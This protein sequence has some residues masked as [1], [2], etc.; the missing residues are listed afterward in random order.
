VNGVRQASLWKLSVVIMSGAA[1]PLFLKSSVRRLFEEKA[2]WRRCSPASL[3]LK[4]R[5]PDPFENTPKVF[6]FDTRQWFWNKDLNFGVPLH[7]RQFL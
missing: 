3:F 5:I 7:N 6:C 4:N 1:L 2:D